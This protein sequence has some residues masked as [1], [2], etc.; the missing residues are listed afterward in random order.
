M[1]RITIVS[2]MGGLPRG[3]HAAASHFPQRPNIRP[4]YPAQRYGPYLILMESYGKRPPGRGQ[5]PSW[6]FFTAPNDVHRIVKKH[7]PER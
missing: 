1:I 5:V 3:S 4:P 2:W 7:D 6:S